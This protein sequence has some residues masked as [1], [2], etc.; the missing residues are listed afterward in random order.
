MVSY[1]IVNNQLRKIIVSA[2]KTGKT[3]IL[4]LFVLFY[5]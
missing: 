1:T 3:M 2:V 4:D 5:S